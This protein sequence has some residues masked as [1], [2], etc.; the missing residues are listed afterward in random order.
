MR[1]IDAD[2]LLVPLWER[3]PLDDDHALG[4]DEFRTF[5]DGVEALLKSAPTV[6][7]D[8]CAYQHDLPYAEDEAFCSMLRV[9]MP[10][11]FG[12]CAYFERREICSA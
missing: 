8:E 3:R 7:C 9:D 12:G 11:D 6:C 1:L 4:R 2:A 10:E 5:C